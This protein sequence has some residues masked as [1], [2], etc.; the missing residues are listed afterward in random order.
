MPN[1]K[2]EGFGS[3]LQSVPVIIVGSHY[4]LVP[5]NRQQETISAIQSLVNEMKVKYVCIF[6]VV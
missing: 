5:A 4:D 2:K 6:C 1:K 3:I